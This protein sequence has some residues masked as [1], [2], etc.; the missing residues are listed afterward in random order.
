MEARRV[1]TEKNGPVWTIIINRPDV[2]NAVD[3]PT[4]GEL[5][6]AF[7]AF[8]ADDEAKAGVLTGAG[9]KNRK[10]ETVRGTW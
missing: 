5:A 10:S 7:R 4:A 9:S 2:R 3:R 1:L 6:D 8:E